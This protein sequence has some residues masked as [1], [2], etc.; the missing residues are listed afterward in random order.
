M[1]CAGLAREAGFSVLGA[2]HRLCQ[3]HRVELAAAETIAAVL[4]DRHIVLPLDLT[5]FGGSA[6]TDDIAVPKD[7]AGEGI[8]VTYV[9]RATRFSSVL[10][11]GLPRR[12]ARAT[13]VIG[14]NALKFGLSRLPAG[15][16]RR[17][18]AVGECSRSRPEWRA[19][20]SPPRAAL[21]H[22]QGRDRAGGGRLGLDAALSHSCYD[23]LPDGRIAAAATRAGCGRRASPKRDQDLTVYVPSPGTKEPRSGMKGW[24]DEFVPLTPLACGESTLSR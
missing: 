3:R 9:R 12:A 7:G 17:V 1:V 2:D 11:S 13:C 4:A 14:V 19:S 10:R 8:P 24:E 16:H 15:V 20:G 5:A 22:D 23:P 6:L 21:A 18:R